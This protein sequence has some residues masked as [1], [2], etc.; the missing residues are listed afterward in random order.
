MR[1]TVLPGT[2][3][4]VSVIA[5]G[6]WALSGDSTWGEQ[7]EADSIAAARSALDAGIN[8]FDTA[9]GYGNGLSEQ[10]LGKGLAG[11]RQ[12]A[13]VATKIGPD[14][15][16]PADAVSSVERSLGYLGTDYIDLLQIHWPSREV[17]LADTWGALER[18]REQGKVRALGVSNFGPLDLAG[19][20]EIGAPATN[21][22]P[23]S[24]LSR[25][26]EF[27]LTPTCA[28]H[29]VGILCYSPLLWGL[30][31]DKYRGPDEVPVGRARSRHFSPNRPQTRHTE[32]G[33]ER[34]TFEALAKIR[35]VAERLGVPMSE[36]AVAWLL[37]QPAV[38][39]VL[40]GV[41]N[42]TQALASARAA[43]LLLD[44][45]TLRELDAATSPVKQALGANPDLWQSGSA[46]RYR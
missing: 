15:M 23:Y 16:R 8:F 37:H 41:R 20:T 19:L 36:L 25:A 42:A 18:L 40:T 44:S 34:E 5:M 39:A 26:V 14:A 43:E 24:L 17:P 2:E 1:Y 6:C 32:A 35:A 33:C 28:S 38:L 11:E 27:Q 9:P 3:I 30:L 4:R 21:Q 13:V 7:S 45:A 22:V 46:S 12:R 31:A 10:R 29:G